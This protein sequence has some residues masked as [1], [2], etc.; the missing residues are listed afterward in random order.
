MKALPERGTYRP[1]TEEEIE[2][3][4]VPMKSLT[5][6]MMCILAYVCIQKK[7]LLAAGRGTAR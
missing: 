7:R 1:F 4:G 6:V 2:R 3:L 5:D